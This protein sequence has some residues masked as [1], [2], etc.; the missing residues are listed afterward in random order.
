M[1]FLTGFE[2][3]PSICSSRFNLSKHEGSPV[4]MRRWIYANAG[5]FATKS[6]SQVG[7]YNSIKTI[8]CCY[9]TS[10]VFGSLADALGYLGNFDCRRSKK[11]KFSKFCS[12]VK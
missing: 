5:I 3:K 9:L 8:K 4:V 6:K 12:I 1:L 10:V 7:Y 11:Y 2:I